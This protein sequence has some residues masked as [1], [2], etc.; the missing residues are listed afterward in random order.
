MKSVVFQ[1]F[2]IWASYTSFNVSSICRGHCGMVVLTWGSTLI[3]IC[4]NFVKLKMLPFCAVLTRAQESRACQSQFLYTYCA[5]WRV[6]SLRI[7]RPSGC[8]WTHFWERVWR[9]PRSTAL[10]VFS[11]LFSSNIWVT[12]RWYQFLKSETK[13]HHVW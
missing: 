1:R 8:V 6:K 4:P 9:M 5:F 10:N 12:A 13:C 11:C 7:P 2:F 3:S